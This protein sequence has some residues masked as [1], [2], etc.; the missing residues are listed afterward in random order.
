MKM[1][2]KDVQKESSIIFI[3]PYGDIQNAERHMVK[4]GYN[5]GAYGWN[6]DAYKVPGSDATI[7]TGYRSF[8][9]GV[10]LSRQQ[11]EELNNAKSTDKI[12]DLLI[13]WT[14]D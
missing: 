4:I 7:V 2:R 14:A 12:R 11:M 10:Y 13:K 8:P 6:W 1:T 3:A 5:A 9:A